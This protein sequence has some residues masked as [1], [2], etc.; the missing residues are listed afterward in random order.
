MIT[1]HS[2]CCKV[3]GEPIDLSFKAVPLVLLSE[4]EVAL[5][6]E[7]VVLIDNALQCS[8]CYVI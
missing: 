1:Y 2:R 3:L 6:Y 4:D 5:D 8:F 7:K